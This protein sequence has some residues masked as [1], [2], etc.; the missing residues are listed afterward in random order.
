LEYGIS[1]TWG[2]GQE[3]VRKYENR[4]AGN[5][6]GG[7]EN[8]SRRLLE[9]NGGGKKMGEKIYH[10]VRRGRNAEG[11]EKRGKSLTRMI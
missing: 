9:R 10:R 7:G 1:A 4:I 2:R 3:G 6:E 5:R 11:T 8:G